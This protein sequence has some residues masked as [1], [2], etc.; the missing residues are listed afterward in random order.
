MARARLAAL[1]AALVVPLGV[2]AVDAPHDAGPNCASCH[3]GHNAPGGSLTHT[4]GNFNLCQSC[5]TRST[6]FGFPWTANDQAVPGVSG[7]SHRWDGPVSGRGATPPAPGSPMAAHLEAGNM[8]CSTCHD[9]HQADALLGAP[10]DPGKL[11][12]QSVSV[13][14]GVALPRTSGPVA[15]STGTLTL[16]RPAAAAA[17]KAYLV[18]IV[19]EGSGTT[20]TF[21]LS[22]DSGASWFGCAAPATYAYVAY[23]SASSA[24]RAG[25][26]VPLNDGTN[27]TVSFA[28]GAAA[29]KAGDRWSFYVSYPF[30]R[31]SSKAS[32][33]CL[34]CHKDRHMTW[35]NAEGQGTLAGTG[36]P[37]Q[38]GVT[39]FSH[40]VGQALNEGGR[41]NGLPGGIL[42]A[43]G[44]LQA[45]GD[46]DPTNDLVLDEGGAVSCLTCH[47]VHNS[48]SNSLTADPR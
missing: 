11:G 46:A 19:T 33:L 6:R 20:A 29:F 4:L 10:A 23:A 41:T 5:H 24:C 17:A 31:V 16:A 39:R 42:D 27:V 9:V 40:P 28:G 38:L 18:E 25:T 15:G 12:R 45:A 21:R 30:L 43:S 14:T 8:K 3:L 44:V 47:R 22:H 2:A 36:A 13:A 35:Q 1:V 32:A 48:D 7:R 26:D 34:E 37:V